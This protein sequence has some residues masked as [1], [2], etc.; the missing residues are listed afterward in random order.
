MTVGDPPPLVCGDNDPE[1][2]AGQDIE[3]EWEV[4]GD[5]DT[6]GSRTQPEKPLR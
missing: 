1:S 4:D 6:V 3:D 2:H 5:G